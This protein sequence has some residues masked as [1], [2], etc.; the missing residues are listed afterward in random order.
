MQATEPDQEAFREATAPAYEV[1]YGQ[2]GDDARD[3]VEAIRG[4]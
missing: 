1:F 3:F 2:F 4:I